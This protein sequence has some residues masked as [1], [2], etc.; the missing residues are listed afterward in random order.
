MLRH[1]VKHISKNLKELKSYKIRSFNYNWGNLEIK[2]QKEI[3]KI[4][5]NV[6]IKQYTSEEPMIPRSHKG[7]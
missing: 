1:Y 4:Y 3:L 5:P 2:K 7:I 6:G